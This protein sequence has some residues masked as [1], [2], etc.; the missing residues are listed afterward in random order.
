MSST[1]LALKSHSVVEPIT[2]NEGI[3]E[4]SSAPT[5]LYIVPRPIDHL[6]ETSASKRAQTT[7]VIA[8]TAATSTEAAVLIPDGDESTAS[9]TEVEIRTERSWWS[10]TTSSSDSDFLSTSTTTDKS[11]GS[12]VMAVA[13]AAG[14]VA[15]M[16]GVGTY[17]AVNGVGASSFAAAEGAVAGVEGMEAAAV[18]REAA[19]DISTD[20]FA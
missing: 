10:S 18:T 15:A 12:N 20:M 17:M 5:T 16:A 13:S 9:V 6:V 11:W 3:T 4:A 7:A 14:G 1:T 2:S 19:Q 8:S